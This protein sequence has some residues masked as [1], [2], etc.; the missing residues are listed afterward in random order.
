M[1]LVWL[2]LILLVSAIGWAWYR[3]KTHP[4][5]KALLA[6]SAAALL[7]LYGMTNHG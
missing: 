7:I 3:P 4:L 1:I 5:I 2:A 6:I